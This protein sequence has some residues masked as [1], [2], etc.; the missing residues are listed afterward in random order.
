LFFVDAA[1]AP[2]G[3]VGVCAIC[4]SGPM[5]NR[6]NGFSGPVFGSPPG[7]GLE[8]VLVSERNLIGNP[9]HT[10]LI[11]DTLGS[12]IEVTTPDLGV[13]ITDHDQLVARGHIPP[14]PVLAFFGIRRAFFANFFKIPTLWG[15]TA[16]APYFHDNSAKDLDEMLEQYDFFFENAP[17]IGGAIELTEQDKEDIKSFLELL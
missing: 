4:H 10:F 13:L 17:Q 7:A 1:F 15:V 11:H 3:K 16:T 5:L 9:L 8:N 14:D 6:T 2:P 12:P